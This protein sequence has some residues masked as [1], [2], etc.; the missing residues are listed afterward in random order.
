MSPIKGRG[1]V[2]GIIK[3]IWVAPICVAV[4]FGLLF[5]RP[6][7]VFPDEREYYAIA[8]NLIAHGFYSMDGMVPTAYRPP[9]YPLFLA[10][11]MLVSSSVVWL[12]VVGLVM[13]IISTLLA[14]RIAEI[15]YGQVAGIFV[16]VAFCVYLVG[17]YTAATLYPQTFAGT[18][19]IAALF[20]CVR[21]NAKNAAIPTM[22]LIGMATLAVPNFVFTIS[23]FFI[24][25]WRD[26]QSFV[27]LMVGICL[28]GVLFVP[29]TYRNYEDF[30]RV[31]PLSTSGGLNLLLGNS[32]NTTPNAGVNTDISRYEQAAPGMSEVEINDF[33]M[34][35]AIDWV[36][37]NKAAAARLFVEKFTNWFNYQNDLA[38]AV[39]GQSVKAL[40]MALVYYPILL[41][42]VFSLRVR[43]TTVHIGR[44][45]MPAI[46]L[47]VALSYAVFFTRIRFRVPFD[48]V[49]IV[50]ASIGA[51]AVW[52]KIRSRFSR[53]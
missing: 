47:L 48:S 18:L 38:T 29:W 28:V 53:G 33:Y 31:I 26:R 36:S 14:K 2:A 35:S 5:V 50:M 49:L 9:S 41:L 32:P 42:A 7:L 1:K 22:L 40:V 10:I 27:R 24:A 12:K 25:L 16:V 52:E 37:S 4:I 8:H 34:Q 44:W 19:L 17:P 39:E 15:L 6:G 30:G 21:C 23:I 43:F 45:L 11:L 13:W 51:A 20:C 3:R 46:Y